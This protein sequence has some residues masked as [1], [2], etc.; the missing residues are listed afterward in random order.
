MSEGSA[1]PASPSIQLPQGCAATS[2]QHSTGQDRTG[3]DR[4]GQDR[5][6]QDRTGQDRTGQDRTVAVL[7]TR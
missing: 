7:L 2:L 6:G 1:A 5:T 4:T 3:Q